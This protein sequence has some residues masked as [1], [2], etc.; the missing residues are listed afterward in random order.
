M[1][2]HYTLYPAREGT[3]GPRASSKTIGMNTAIAVDADSGF[4]SDSGGGEK[5][6]TLAVFAL[7]GLILLLAALRL[8]SRRHPHAHRY[9]DSRR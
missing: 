8:L 1:V 7:A 5:G 3:N 9:P 4:A 2:V 6:A